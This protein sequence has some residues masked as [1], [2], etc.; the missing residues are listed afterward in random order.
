MKNYK[1]DFCGSE[2]IQ[3]EDEDTAL[4]LLCEKFNEDPYKYVDLL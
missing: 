1:F 4:E 2:D 3:A